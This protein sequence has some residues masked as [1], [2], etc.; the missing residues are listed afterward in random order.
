MTPSYLTHRVKQ[1]TTPV[2]FFTSFL[3]STWVCIN[4]LTL[5][6]GA[7]TVFEMIPATPPEIKSWI[8]EDCFGSGTGVILIVKSDKIKIQINWIYLTGRL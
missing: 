4:N 8:N 5:S 3:F 1:S 6:T 7:T 2:Y